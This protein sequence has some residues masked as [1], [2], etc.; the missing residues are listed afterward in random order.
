MEVIPGPFTRRDGLVSTLIRTGSRAKG[1]L[2]GRCMAA[3]TTGPS[4]DEHGPDE[5]GTQKQG[6]SPGKQHAL[7]RSFSKST[8]ELYIPCV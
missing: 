5:S 2:A 6:S 7:A 1:E 4:W 8:R 3:Y